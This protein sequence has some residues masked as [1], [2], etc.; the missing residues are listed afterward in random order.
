MRYKVR[1]IIVENIELKVAQLLLAHGAKWELLGTSGL[2]LITLPQNVQ[3]E[4]RHEQ[5]TISFIDENGIRD[6][7]RWLDIDI[8]IDP[9]RNELR[10]RQSRFAMEAI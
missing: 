3:V 7:D 9:Y 6:E 4:G 10:Y 2:K 5:Y 1:Q 8:D